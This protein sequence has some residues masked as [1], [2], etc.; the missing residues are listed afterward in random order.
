MSGY[1]SEISGVL[2]ESALSIPSLRQNLYNAG[3]KRKCPRLFD[4]KAYGRG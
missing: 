4:S 1:A 2:T 3:S